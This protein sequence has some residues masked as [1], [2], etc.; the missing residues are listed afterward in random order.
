MTVSVGWGRIGKDTKSNRLRTAQWPI[1][2]C[3][4]NEQFDDYITTDR[5]FCRKNTPWESQIYLGDSGGPVLVEHQGERWQLGWVTYNTNAL[6][7]GAWQYYSISHKAAP[8]LPW[9]QETIEATP[10]LEYT[11]IEQDF[12]E[13]HRQ[14][15]ELDDDILEFRK[16]LVELIYG[17]DRLRIRTW[18]AGA[19]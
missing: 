14:A 18:E 15:R 7:D 9:I 13:L 4:T 11:S 3:P 12:Q 19:R 10:V 2:P 6:I 1:A 16:R 5:D 17:I 8:Y